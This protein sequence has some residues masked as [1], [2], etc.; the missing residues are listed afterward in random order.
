MKRHITPIWDDSYKN[1]NYRKEP[2]NGHDD[3]LKWRS[4]GYNQ[5]EIYFTGHMCPFGEVHPVWTQ[6]IIN[7]VQN[8]YNLNDIGIC[9]YK[10]E[11]GVILPE[12]SD[13]YINYIKKFKCD[14]NQIN[15]ILIFLEDWKSGHYFEIDGTPI[16]NW[17]KGDCYI[18]SGSTKHMAA[19]IGP[20]DRYTLQITGWK[21]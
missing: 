2:F 10:M 13:Y 5:D 1:L 7:W 21:N 4:L 3:L 8:E 17:S 14:I 19:N 16:V 6:D 20:Q 18:W 15:R 9:F 11:T 12:H